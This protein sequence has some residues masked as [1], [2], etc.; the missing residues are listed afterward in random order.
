MLQQATLRKI[1]A[2][3]FASGALATALPAAASAQTRP[4]EM[5]ADQAVRLSSFGGRAA[6]SP[7]GARIAFGGKSYGD[8]YE[9]EIATGK[10]RN[11]TRNL[12]HQGVMR[13][14]YLPNGDY[15]V[16]A[17]RR[18]AGANTRAHL[19]MWVLDKD[20]Q[21]GLQPLG[22]QVFEGVAVSRDKNLIAWTVIE[23]E[24]KPQ[25]NWQLAFVRPTK[26]YIAEI[27]YENGAPKIAN[28]RELMPV[29]PKE[30]SFIEPQDFRDRDKELVYSCMSAANGGLLISVMGHRIDTGEFITYLRKPGEYNEVE[31]VSPDGKW[32]TVECGKQTG[33]GLPPLDICRLELK[34]NGAVSRL[35][36]GTA[37][38]TTGDVSNPVVSPDGKWIAFQ[39]SDSAS[40]EIGEG[41]GLYRMKVGE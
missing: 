20:L 18:Y 11:L 35:I 14:Q 17:P 4:R 13:I 31:G 19:E 7:D 2:L 24:L 27:S 30:C 37:P 21:R 3:A 8:A 5:Q 36:V 41:Y 23:P 22:E 12:P 10:V 25:E 32:A 16:T 34:P 40:G 38:G 39:K 15:L 33:P 28:K 6:Y 1:L 29:L 9:V 26:R